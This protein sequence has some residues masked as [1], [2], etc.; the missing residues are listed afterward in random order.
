MHN[1]ESRLQECSNKHFEPKDEPAN[2]SKSQCKICYE[3]QDVMLIT[4]CGHGFCQQCWDK[5]VKK[6]SPEMKKGKKLLGGCPY[7][8]KDVDLGSLRK[9]YS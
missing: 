4:A 7:C 6:V 9:F 5:Y 8:R 1:T 3:P 2:I